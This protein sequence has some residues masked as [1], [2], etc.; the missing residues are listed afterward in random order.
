MGEGTGLYMYDVVVKTF[1]FSISY[2]DEFL[3]SVVSIQYVAIGLRGCSIIASSFLYNYRNIN[4][5]STCY[6]IRF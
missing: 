3:Y 2:T 6:Y 1:T 4:V 5:K